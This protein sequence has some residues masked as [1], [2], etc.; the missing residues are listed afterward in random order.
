MRRWR[1]QHPVHQESANPAL[2][3]AAVRYSLMIP[4]SGLL[5]IAPVAAAPPA[6]AP[7][8]VPEHDVGRVVSLALVTP[9]LAAEERFYAGLFGWT[10]DS[11]PA[12]HDGPAGTVRAARAFLGSDPVAAL[13]ERPVPAGEHR[14]PAWLTFFSVADVGA[15]EKLARQNGAKLLARPIL[16]GD[17][18]QDAVLADPQG[19]VFAVM[20]ASHGDPPD[21]LGEPGA[22]IWSS[23]MTRDPDTDAAFYQQ[24]FGDDVYDV[25]ADEREEHLLLAAGGYARASVN[26]L[27]A[28][29]PDAH[30]YWLNYVRV[31]DAAASAQKAVALGGHV[32]V[33]PRM[34]RQ[35]GRVAVVADPMGAPF[36]LLEWQDTDDPTGGDP[37]GPVPGPMQVPQ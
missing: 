33:E 19:A 4:L 3:R 14:Q 36:G 31:A 11:S 25:S 32:L 15:A 21:V 12:G 13:F 29:R 18:G 1:R 10:F 23:L 7:E 35:G 28:N 22:W 34:D 26:P 20:A 5:G 24:L 8:A 17:L 30:P 2:L 27:P 9:D 16:P 6:L 37:T